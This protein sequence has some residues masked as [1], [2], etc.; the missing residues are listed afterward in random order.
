MHL[1]RSLEER[2]AWCSQRFSNNKKLPPAI[3]KLRTDNYQRESHCNLKW[4]K[5]GKHPS[6]SLRNPP[7][8]SVAKTAENSV[9]TANRQISTIRNELRN[10]KGSTP[11]EATLPIPAVKENHRNGRWT[12]SESVSLYDE[13]NHTISL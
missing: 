3:A 9:T 12:T 10:M 5:K 4:Q 8:T 6:L 1:R 7:Q 13:H 11:L 2:S